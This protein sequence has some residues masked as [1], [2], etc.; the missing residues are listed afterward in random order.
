MTSE[1][2]YRLHTSL[3]K[4]EPTGKSCSLT[5][6][7]RGYGAV[8]P[9]SF[10]ITAVKDALLAIFSRPLINHLTPPRG[11]TDRA[12]DGQMSHDKSSARR[13][14]Q[15]LCDA[16]F[17]TACSVPRDPIWQLLRSHLLCFLCCLI[18]PDCHYSSLFHSGRRRRRVR[19]KEKKRGKDGEINR[20]LPRRIQIFAQTPV[21]PT[22]DVIVENRSNWKQMLERRI[23]WDGSVS[24]N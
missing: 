9:S 5:N 8:E 17:P 2:A 22:R 10:A 4:W 13:W 3:V 12:A 6:G 7:A 21:K 1:A 16:V 18:I 24:Q 23:I 14:H 19:W 11:A 15:S 20:R